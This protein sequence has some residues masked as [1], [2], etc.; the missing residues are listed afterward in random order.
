MSTNMDVLIWRAEEIDAH[1]DLLTPAALQ[2]M[3]DRIYSGMAIPLEFDIRNIIGHVVAPW[4]KGKELWATVT[5]D[6]PGVVDA[7]NRGRA[8]VRPGF[9]IA[10][11]HADNGP[12]S[13]VID[14]VTGA[15]VSVTMKPMHLPGDAE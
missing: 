5:I 4:I 12:A 6:D 7:L 13:R 1:G 8:S 14:H 15:S 2:D 10:E 9:E 3:A 11:Q